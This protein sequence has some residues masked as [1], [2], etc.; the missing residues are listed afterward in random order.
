MP[1]QGKVRK[2]L[3]KA[4]NDIDGQIVSLYLGMEANDS[5]NHPVTGSLRF[6]SR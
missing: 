1:K 2:T 5:T 4:Q 3:A 6:R